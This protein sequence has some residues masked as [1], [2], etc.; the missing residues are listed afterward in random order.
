MTY[1]IKYKDNNLKVSVDE[2]HKLWFNNNIF[3]LTFDKNK[4]TIIIDNNSEIWSKLNDIL[5]IIKY[6]KEI[7]SKY[8]TK[9][10]E[11]C[12]KTEF[13]NIKGLYKIID[14]SD[15][16]NKEKFNKFLKK[17]FP[18]LLENKSFLYS[19]DNLIKTT[20]LINDNN[21]HKFINN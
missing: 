6:N 16:K 19:N 15:Y 21:L 18:I 8:L 11:Y 2:E 12:D 13:I 4:I 14:K 5:I 3:E 10:I 20:K 1:N 7:K 17:S 9:H